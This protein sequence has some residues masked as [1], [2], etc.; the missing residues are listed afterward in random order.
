M[1][2]KSAETLSRQYCTSQE[3]D[4][5]GCDWYHHSWPVLRALGVFHSL[6]SD[7]DFLVRAISREIALGA[8][9]VL[10]SGAAD[11][12]ILARVAASAKD[13][14]QLDI[15]VLDQCETPLHLNKQFAEKMGFG[16]QTAHDNILNHVPSAPYDL[17]CTHSFITFFSPDQR[18]KLVARW[19]GLLTTNG[20][21]I[22]AQ[23]IRP[24]ETEQI[25]RFSVQEVQRLADESERLAKEKFSYLGIDPAK[26]RELGRA[27]GE[28]HKTHLISSEHELSSLF[29]EQGFVL[30][31]FAPPS[32]DAPLKD[33]PGAPQNALS[34][35]WR[36][37][38]RKP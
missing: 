26:A 25:T 38:A 9:R 11:A 1:A 14:A 32:S 20:C 22:T 30:D 35:R 21:V 17:I 6:A 8:R 15:T 34:C 29:I 12:G 19:H 27:Y 28:R 5:D 23:R 37:H 3:N 18:K 7:D 2:A 16:I 4:A 36:I 10:I 31:E 13:I 24:N 33:R